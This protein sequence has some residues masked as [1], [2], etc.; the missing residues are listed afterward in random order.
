MSNDSKWSVKAFLQCLISK[1]YYQQNTYHIRLIFVFDS[2]NQFY[3]AENNLHS[4]IKKISFDHVCYFSN[5]LFIRA[6]L[7]FLYARNEIYSHKYPIFQIFPLNI[8]NRVCTQNFD[9]KVTLTPYIFSYVQKSK[10]E[11]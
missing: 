2:F 5:T 7:S 4:L 6:V 9:N 3:L 11:L 1:K 10:E 8:C